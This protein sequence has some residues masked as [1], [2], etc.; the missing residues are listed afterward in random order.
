MELYTV[1]V[2]GVES[3]LELAKAAS[4]KPTETIR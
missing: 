1:A 3:K 2:D 4:C